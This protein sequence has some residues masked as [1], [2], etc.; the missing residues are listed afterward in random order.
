MRIVK[1]ATFLGAIVS[2][3][4][5]ACSSEEIAGADAAA[6]AS[7]P[8]ARA[9]SVERPWRGECDVDAQFI[10]EFT[11]RISGTCQLAHIGRAS[12]VEYQ[13]IAPGPNGIGYTNTAIYTSAGGD[14]LHT[15]NS[16]IAT[17]GADG[18]L[19]SGIE[20]AAGGTG[21]FVNASGA[22]T[23]IGAVRFTG[24]TTTTGTYTLEGRLTF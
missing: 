14:E 12:V 20:T 19:L 17:P 5:N 10:G 3:G 16:G 13:T 1:R 23:L 6:V 8:L 9:L 11:L 24:P 7:N 2:L 15:T 4:I 22:A 21:R 18:L